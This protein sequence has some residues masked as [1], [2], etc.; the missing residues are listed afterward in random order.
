MKPAAIPPVDP[1]P[2]LPNTRIC[3]TSVPD[4]SAKSPQ[5]QRAAKVAVV[6]EIQQLIDQRGG[7][8]DVVAMRDAT[9]GDGD[10]L[11]RAN[12]HR[13]RPGSHPRL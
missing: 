12:A 11:L 10:C 4:K 9:D 2:R 7:V 5:G 1:V 6:H 13:A 8:D 3:F